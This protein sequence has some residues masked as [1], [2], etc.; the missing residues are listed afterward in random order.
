[1]FN[2]HVW[3]LRIQLQVHSYDSSF[4]FPL[5]IS[6][7][8]HSTGSQV[9]FLPMLITVSMEL[10]MVHMQALFQNFCILFALSFSIC[11]RSVT[12]FLVISSPAKCY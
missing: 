6:P 9:G 12:Q 11:S 5:S 4:H 3:K 10:V 2:H 1:M 7:L 8:S